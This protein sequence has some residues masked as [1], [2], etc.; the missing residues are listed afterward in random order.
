M[1]THNRSINARTTYVTTTTIIVIGVPIMLVLSA[2][3][4]APSS[5]IQLVY[6]QGPSTSRQ[7]DANNL[8]FQTTNVSLDGTSYPVKYNI[9]E[10]AAEVLSI[11]ADKESFK[12]VITI[13]PTKDGKL[14]VMIPRNLTDYKVAGGKDG[15][16]LVNINAKEI[17]NF[18][19]I[20]NNQTTRGLEIN[21]GKDD[22][23]IEIVGTQMGQADIAEVKKE[24]TEMSSPPPNTQN[25]TDNASQAGTSI[26]NQTGEAAQ[27]FVNKSTS[28]IGNLTGEVGELLK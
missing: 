28:V 17:T 24:A 21:F 4:V 3:A 5:A 1:Q 12:L 27:T 8:T 16:F 26:V 22:R 23:V 25:V 6:S 20:S 15:K 19:E 10:N 2:I 14:T 18:Q 7:Q 9:T 11:A 13:A